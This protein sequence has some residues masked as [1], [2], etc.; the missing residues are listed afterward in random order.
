MLLFP[1]NSLY[2][3]LPL[4]SFESSDAEANCPLKA[5]EGVL[6]LHLK[7]QN[8]LMANTHIS[9]CL[10]KAAYPMEQDSVHGSH[11]I[12]HFPD[13]KSITNFDKS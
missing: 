12:L 5:L 6:L 13:C 11:T 8:W 3:Y 7:I 1:G 4:T 9:C 10:E 2:E